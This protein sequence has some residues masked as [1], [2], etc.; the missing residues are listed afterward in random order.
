MTIDP[1]AV[2]ADFHDR[3]RE[4]LTAHD[5]SHAGVCAC[6]YLEGGAD[7]LFHRRADHIHHV[8]TVVRAEIWAFKKDSE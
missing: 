6:G 5:P 8:A 4:T 2:A 7:R 3:I 1:E